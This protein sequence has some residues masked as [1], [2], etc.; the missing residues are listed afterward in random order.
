MTVAEAQRRLANIADFRLRMQK[1]LEV[2]HELR[3]LKDYAERDYMMS[4]FD[5]GKVEAKGQ[6]LLTRYFEARANV[7]RCI[8]EAT[9]T[10][11]SFRIPSQIQIPPP[12]LVGGYARAFNIYQAALEE[13]LPFKYDLPP[14]KVMDVLDQTVF[15]SERLVTQAQQE[16]ANRPSPLVKVPGVLSKGILS[17]FKT[18]TDKAIL[19]WSVIVL[20]VVTIL[21]LVGMPVQKIGELVASWLT[22]K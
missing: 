8:A 6:D 5:Q 3:E 4:H 19:K 22:K 7:A 21:R 20:L 13:E 1:F 9:E 15:A 18:E 11:D 16:E 10:T 17:I 12:P 14:M 2:R